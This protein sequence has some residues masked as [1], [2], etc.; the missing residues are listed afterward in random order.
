MQ[1]NKQ[2]SWE[3]VLRHCMGP[4]PENGHRDS[5]KGKP[6][7]IR[8]VYKKAHRSKK[9]TQRTVITT[10]NSSN[11]SDNYYD[12]FTND[13]QNI[14]WYCLH[15]HWW[16]R[17]L[18]LQHVRT[19]QSE[20]I[21]QK[22]NSSTAAAH[23]I[24]ESSRR[25]RPRVRDEPKTKNGQVRVMYNDSHFDKVKMS[26]NNSAWCSRLHWA[27]LPSHPPAF[28]SEPYPLEATW[29]KLIQTLWSDPRNSW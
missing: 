18:S 20:I 23:G 27:S 24:S 1:W 2:K 5:W 10:L 13:N 4:P 19:F 11:Q 22:K 7:S 8:L 21:K 17:R 16:V 12:I 6:L 26:A 3:K 28:S 29:K 14:Q 25:R 15:F 9:S